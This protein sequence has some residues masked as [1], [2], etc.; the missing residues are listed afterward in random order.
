MTDKPLAAMAKTKVSPADAKRIQQTIT[1][2]CEQVVPILEPHGVAIAVIAFETEGG[3]FDCFQTNAGINQGLVDLLENLAGA[4]REK[5]LDP[6]P[7]TE[8]GTV[9]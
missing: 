4:L 3:S 7:L 1:A 8:E 5:I 2:M 6:P 9:H